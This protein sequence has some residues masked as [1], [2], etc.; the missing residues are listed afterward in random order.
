MFKSDLLACMSVHRMLSWCPQRSLESVGF[1][2][3]EFW[4]GVSC[5]AGARN[6]S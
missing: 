1:L 6:R 3:T 2:G 5:Y 4:T